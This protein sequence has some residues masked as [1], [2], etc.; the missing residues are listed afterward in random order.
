MEEINNTCSA[1]PSAEINGA[2]KELQATTPEVDSPP[3]QM[4]EIR[5]KFN[6]ET[7]TLTPD[8]AVTLAQKGLKYDMVSEDLKRLKN[9]A[10]ATGK[11]IS[12]YITEIENQTSAAHKKALL[13]SCSGNSEIVEHIM[14]LE[15]AQSGI[16]TPG[17][18]EILREF[19][20]I[21]SLS[22]LPESVLQTVEIKGGN[23]FDAYLRYQHQQKRQAAEQRK[24]QQKAAESSV[25]SQ[26]GHTGGM[27]EV[28]MEFING[29]WN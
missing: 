6:K 7:R 14:E 21:K 15:G 4:S 18:D 17:F 27:S 28:N 2:D 22:D 12:D 20:E 13:D 23:L 5:V 1:A 9:L 10:G 19:P 8:E 24:I 25:G 16:A 29:L 3:T 26:K 11:N